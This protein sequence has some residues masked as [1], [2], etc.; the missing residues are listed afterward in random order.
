MNTPEKKTY[1]EVGSRIADNYW[2]CTESD[3]KQNIVEWLYDGDILTV[4]QVKM[5]DEEYKLLPEYEG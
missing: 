5:T 1:Y 2:V 3:L 4:E